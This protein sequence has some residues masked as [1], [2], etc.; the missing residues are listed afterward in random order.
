MSAESHGPSEACRRDAPFALQSSITNSLLEAII[1]GTVADT[2]HGQ[3]QT[4]ANWCIPKTACMGNFVT[5]R[6][7]SF[8][9]AGEAPSFGR[10][11]D[12]VDR[13]AKR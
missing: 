7:L 13:A 10:L 6:P 4:W 5:N 9:S 8:G 11:K 1:G 3:V 2:E 12:K